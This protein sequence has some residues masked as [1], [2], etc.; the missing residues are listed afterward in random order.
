MV[1][2]VAALVLGVTGRSS[3]LVGEWTWWPEVWSAQPWI[4][5]VAALV[6]VVSARSTVLVEEWTWWPEAWSV[7]S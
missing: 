1:V 5:G 6:L 3:V 7:W 2:G 4:V